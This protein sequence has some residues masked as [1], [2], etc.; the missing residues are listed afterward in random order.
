VSGAEEFDAFRA[1]LNPEGPDA[2]AFKAITEARINTQATA[3]PDKRFATM[4]ARAALVGVSLVRSTDDRGRPTFVAS[5][6]SMT[7]QLDSIEA[8]EQ[9]LRL[10]GGQHA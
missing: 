9:F 10:V 4:Q 6:W 7:R 8:V 1:I 3:T 5:K 2:T